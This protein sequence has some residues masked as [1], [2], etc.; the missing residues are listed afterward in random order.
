MKGKGITC[1]AASA[2]LAETRMDAL[3]EDLR[4]AVREHLDAC[5][6][7]R[8]MVEFVEGVREMPASKPGFQPD[9]IEPVKPMARPWLF[10]GVALLALAL[11]AWAGVAWNGPYGWHALDTSQAALFVLLCAAGLVPLALGFYREFKPGAGEGVD[12]RLIVAALV[13]VY[14]VYSASEFVWAGNVGLNPGVGFR[15]FR[16]GMMISLAGAVTLLLWARQGF[17]ANPTSAAVWTGAF[18]SLSGIIALQIHCPV[19]ETS[20]LLLGHAPVIVVATYL[21]VWMSRRVFGLK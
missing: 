15:C 10:I 18:S 12:N 7:C 17:A 9:V 13:L 8:A 5:P 4:A 14:A 2:H 3:P 16:F 1:T 11:F 6:N 21:T 20:H 19:L